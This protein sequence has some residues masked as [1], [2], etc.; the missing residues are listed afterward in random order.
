MAH[1]DAG[2]EGA[3]AKNRNRILQVVALVLVACAVVVA[4]VA[5]PE[6]ESRRPFTEFSLRNPEGGAAASPL[7]SSIQE[8]QEL[9]IGVYNH[10]YANQAYVLEIFLVEESYDPVAN[11]TRIASMDLLER[12]SLNLSH[13]EAQEFAF[14]F[15]IDSPRY[16][17]IELL[18]HKDSA[19]P[20]EIRNEDRIN[21]S[22]RDLHLWIDTAP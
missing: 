18:L 9:V 21:A 22:Y 4:L 13:D 5:F 2:N 20:G 3:N 1:E 19:P 12:H 16:N 11:V 15:G 14:T 6:A 10:E 17:K 7:Q 8:P